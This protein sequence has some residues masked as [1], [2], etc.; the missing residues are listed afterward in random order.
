MHLLPSLHVNDLQRVIVDG[1]H[2]KTLT[3]HVNAEVINATFD[4]GKRDPGLKG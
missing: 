3:L 2:K 1:G 4:I